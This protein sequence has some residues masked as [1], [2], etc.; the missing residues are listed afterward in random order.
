MFDGIIKLRR[1]GLGKK[2]GTDGHLDSLLGVGLYTVSESVDVISHRLS[3]RVDNRLLLRW[4]K[5]R[6]EASK[7]YAA[8]TEAPLKIADTNLFT[9]VQLIELMTIAALRSKGVKSK[10]I[11]LAYAA[12]KERYGDYPF[13]RERFR[14]DGIGIFPGSDDELMEELSRGQLFFKNVIEPILMDVSY[15]NGCAV[16]FSPLGSDKSVILDPARAFGSPIDKET[17]VPTH[18]LYAM[19]QSGEAEESVAEWY[20]VSIKGVRD[21]VEYE[22]ALQLKA[23]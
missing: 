18:V 20:G 12:R 7:D 15:A 16:T 13:A 2:S 4:S 17:G 1:M 14:T 19:R 5:G 3:G 10:A 23:A 8:I 6:R 9:F 21:A 11:R 22:S